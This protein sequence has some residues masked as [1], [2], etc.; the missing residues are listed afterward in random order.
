VTHGHGKSD[1]AIVAKKRANKTGQPAAE[2]VERR[3]EA[4]K[5]LA[6]TVWT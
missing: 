4:S 1:S 5:C 6:M 2:R 3:V